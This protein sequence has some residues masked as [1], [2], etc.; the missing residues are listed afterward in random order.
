[1]KRN[2]VVTSLFCFGFFLPFMGDGLFSAR[3]LLMAQPKTLIRID[4]NN[5]QSM[6]QAIERRA[7]GFQ[8]TVGYIVKDLQTGQVVSYH[9]DSPFL[10]ASLIKLPIMVA[11]F[12]AVEEGILSLDKQIVLKRSDK[13]GGSGILKRTSVGTLLSNRQLVE[14][15]IIHSDNTA[16]ELLVQQLGYDYLRLTFSKLGL[17][18][19]V[20]HPDGFKL[21]PKYVAED[22]Y[23]SPQDMAFLLEEIYKG[24]LISAQASWDMLEILMRQ[25]LRDRLPKLLPEETIVAHKTGLLRRSCHDVGIVFSPQGDYVICVLTGENRN[26]NVAKSLISTVGQ[27]AF[28]YMRT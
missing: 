28:E 19:T 14:A 4:P 16:T 1:M 17:T 26:Y 24:R 2:T 27:K 3:S 18:N 5:W 23:T 6:V 15:M 10:S 22:N 13:R 25:K 9:A 20:I 8:G 11:V 21:S 12:Q 7:A